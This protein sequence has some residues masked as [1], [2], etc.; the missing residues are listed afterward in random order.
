MTV[1]LT[2]FKRYYETPGKEFHSYDYSAYSVAVYQPSWY[3]Q[4]TKLDL[5][6]IRDPSGQW[7]RPRDF[8]NDD[9]LG[10]S[11]PPRDYAL[12]RRYHDALLGMY[13]KRWANQPEDRQLGFLERVADR[14]E[15]WCCWCPYD[16]A[17]QRQL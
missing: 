4:L 6:D 3:A 10:G 14:D 13:E 17:A 2:S 15:V 12:L 7:V 16:K 9:W 1:Y 8:I 5:F 11:P